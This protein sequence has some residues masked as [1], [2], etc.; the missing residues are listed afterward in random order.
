MTRQAHGPGSL[1]ANRMGMTLEIVLHWKHETY[2][3]CY[4]SMLY[5]EYLGHI[6]RATHLR[7]QSGCKLLRET[8]TWKLQ[9]P[10]NYSHNTPPH[11]AA[12]LPDCLHSAR[13][14]LYRF[15]ELIHPAP[16]TEVNELRSDEAEIRRA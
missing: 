9:S 4:S 10:P 16:D 5:R 6:A 15:N 3:S 2:L 1:T 12:P 11:S 7:H 13:C 8:T 14:L